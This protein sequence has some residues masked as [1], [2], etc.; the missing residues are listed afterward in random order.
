MLI[1]LSLIS[2]LFWNIFVLFL[3][4]F[5]HELGHVLAS[6]YYKW[7]I[8]KI[9]F[10]VTGGFITYDTLIDMP[11]YQE[12][13]ISISGF[14]AQWLMYALIFLMYKNGYIDIKFFIL[15]KNYHYLIFF[16]N[17]LPMYPLDGY[18]IM[19]VLLN[20]FFSFK[21]SIKMGGLISLFMIIPFMLFFYNGLNIGIL[22]LVFFILKKI[23][24]YLKDI[25]YL[26]NTFLLQ[27]YFYKKRYKK[28]NYINSININ[29]LKRQKNNYLYNKK[30]YIKD[31][32]VLRKMFD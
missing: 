10:S 21:F 22:F 32:D 26:F 31:T 1:F 9:E 18:K 11:F 29:K 27:K 20:V 6:L 24:L 12:L 4:I 3:I 17:L 19:Y 28:Y 13:I 5:I 30:R 25:P 15:M 14:M 8:S 23:I 2:G 7:D 16:F